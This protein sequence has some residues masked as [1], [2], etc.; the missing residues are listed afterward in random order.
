MTEDINAFAP[1]GR[2]RVEAT[3]SG[4]LD[5][6]T[7]VAK[8]LFDV[9]G[10]VTGGGNPDWASH[11]AIPSRHAWAV[12]TLLDAGACLTGKTIT[13]E[14]SLGIL[15]ENAFYGTPLNSAAPDRVPGGSSSGTAAA[16]AGGL[17]DTG[18]GSDTGGSIR[19]PASFCGLYGIRPTHGRLNLAGMMP[20]AP[21][22]D[23]T[24]WFARDANTFERVSSVLLGETINSAL[25][26]RLVIAVD[27]FGFAD[28]QTRE[29]L[30]PLVDKIAK[31]TGNV[32]E[33]VMAPQGI[34]VWGRTQRT[35]QMAQAWQTFQGWIEKTNPRV[36][37]NVAR[38]LLMGSMVPEVD[39]Q[40]AMLMKHEARARLEYLLPQ[41]SVLVMPT[42]PF[43]APPKNL[44]LPEQ[45]QVREKILG[46]CAHGG[47]AGFPQVSI[48]GA[49]VDG[50]PVG[51]SIL[52]GA[53]EDA[54]LVA[55]ASEL[56]SALASE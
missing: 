12:Q 7:F 36:S 8:D 3:S 37:F 38:G 47:L 35:L 54:S 17:A 56:A 26:T 13:D 4:P 20:Q 43:P 45:N 21:D 15:G 2:I 9:A 41:G 16:V 48:P 28:P 39:K 24:G 42:T 52:A 31:L 53:D 19:V 6:L 51:L 49:T 46:L 10:H 23:T 29:A 22:S 40:W 32:V 44:P 25:P 14:V 30:Y 11:N 27:T 1:E 18:L 50:A 34:S 55:L 33:E 5:G